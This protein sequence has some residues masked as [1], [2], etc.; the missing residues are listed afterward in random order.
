MNILFPTISIAIRD[1]NNRGIYPDLVRQFAN[2]GH[3]VYVIFPVGMNESVV[4]LKIGNVYQLGIPLTRIIKASLPERLWSML[5][6]SRMFERAI[7]REWSEVRFDLILYATPPI[8]FNSLISR[9]KKKHKAHTYLMLKD[10]F[11]QNAVDLGILSSKG[12]AYK[13]LK[14]QENNLYELSD[15]IG[16]MSQGN[17]E[18]LKRHSHSDFFLKT[19]ICPNAVE[20][21]RS[22]LNAKEKEMTREEY[23]LP[24]DKVLVIYG[25]NLGKPQ[26]VDFLKQVLRNQSQNNKLHFVICGTGTEAKDLESFIAQSLFDNVSFWNGLSRKEYDRLEACSDVALVF[27]DKRFTIPNYPSRILSYMEHA[28]PILFSV[29]SVTDVG[30]DAEING[31]GLNT[32]HG[33]LKEFS[34]ALEK[35]VRDSQ[36]RRNMGNK[37]RAYL[38][39]HF[40]VEKAYRAI[41][42]SI[43]I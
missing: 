28:L 33:N 10:I 8:T 3:H 17:V 25:G 21:K 42:E 20:L 26:G 27:L 24:K 13:H 35:L 1:I 39:Q 7:E 12:I 5:R 32:E 38:E 23:G 11:P 9:L 40:T 34:E 37:G 22:P 2:E 6:I 4:N 41:I 36:L 19:E 31:Y 29:D 15:K 18:Y 14:K 43:D 16:C 30:R